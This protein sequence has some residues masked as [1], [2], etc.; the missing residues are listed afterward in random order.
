MH[1]L[2]H[3]SRTAKVHTHIHA[4]TSISTPH[5]DVVETIFAAM[6]ETTS[7]CLRR[8]ACIPTNRPV[9]ISALMT[10]WQS[11]VGGLDWNKLYGVLAEVLDS[12]CMSLVLDEG[13]PSF[14]LLHPLV[15]TYL[16]KGLD[17]DA[18][19]L[20][21]D[22][23][24]TSAGMPEDCFKEEDVNTW[25]QMQWD[26]YF[27]SHAPEHMHKV[28]PHLVDKIFADG[29]WLLSQHDSTKVDKLCADYK[30][31]GTSAQVRRITEALEVAAPA[32]R[33]HPWEVVPQLL[34]RL[35]G[36]EDLTAFCA[37]L[38]EGA[39]AARPEDKFMLWL[40][41]MF[42]ADAFDPAPEDA[43]G[44]AATCVGFYK[45]YVVT[46]HEDGRVVLWSMRDGKKVRELVGHTAAVH[47]AVCTEG[48]ELATGSKDE[49]VGARIRV[50]NLETGEAVVQGSLPKDVI[51]SE[52]SAFNVKVLLG[53][54][55]TDVRDHDDESYGSY[56]KKN[57]V[58]DT[59]LVEHQDDVEE[60][61]C[62]TFVGWEA[63]PAAASMTLGCNI[64]E[65]KMRD[66]DGQLVVATGDAH[67]RM[68]LFKLMTHD[69][70]RPADGNGSDSD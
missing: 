6:P 32:L 2:I 70:P 52:T 30:R 45:E 46:G 56:N 64:A 21:L 55:G 44:S 54:T 10:F 51:K 22:A 37:D 15:S 48:G 16:K 49:E 18:D 36:V 59:V 60:I 17:G 13:Y 5:S 69:A 50:W 23:Y 57:I 3:Y 26:G 31:Y 14:V 33:R 12:G 66:V 65:V 61:N 20:L 40:T 63:H 25:I 27:H 39:R 34:S 9:F 47:G 58:T 68:L 41:P 1:L 11:E 8:L 28:A 42:E 38:T 43:I 29:R 24:R 7:K 35:R 62:H 19:A 67:G 53:R 4:S